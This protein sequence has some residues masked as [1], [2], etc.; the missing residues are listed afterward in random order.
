MFV[1]KDNKVSRK[2]GQFKIVELLNN[3]TY[4][5]CNGV[6]TFQQPQRIEFESQAALINI[7]IIASGG[8]EGY[9]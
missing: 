8:V 1:F 7:D 3:I 6:E 2:E 9:V 4:R 5:R